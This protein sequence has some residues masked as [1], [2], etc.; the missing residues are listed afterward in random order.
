MLTRVDLM[1]MANSL[2]VR[3]PL[4]DYHVV[5][6]AL[7]IPGSEKLRRGVTK[8]FLKETFSELLPPATPG[9][10]NPVSD[11]HQPLAQDGAE[12]SG[13]PL[14]IRRADPRSGNL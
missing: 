4:L 8:R 5:E 1:S 9:S 13:R 6:L 12:F 3:V 7:Q 10:R 14:S 11:P 2:E